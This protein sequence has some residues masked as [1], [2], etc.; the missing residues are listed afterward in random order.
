MTIEQATHDWV[1]EFNAVP[2][3]VIRKLASLRE[4]ES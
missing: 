2:T 1:S 4:V 3:A